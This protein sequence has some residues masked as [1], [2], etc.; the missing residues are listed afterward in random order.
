MATLFSVR[1]CLGSISMLAAFATISVAAQPPVTFRAGPD[2]KPVP[3]NA[4][5]DGSDAKPGTPPPGGKPGQKPGEEKKPGEDGK[6]DSPEPKVIRRGDKGEADPSELKATVGEDGRVAFQFR[7]QPWGELVQWLS[8]IT[9]QP[10]D[11]QE[12][13]GDRV[14]LASP[15]RYTVEETRDLFNRHLLSRGY[16]ILE[17]DGGLTIVKTAN[18]NPAMVPRV[19]VEELRELPPHTFVRTSLDVGWLSAEKLAQELTPMISSN[20]RLTALT[21]TNRIEAMDA[22]VNLSQINQ[23][24]IQERDSGSREALAPGI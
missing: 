3:V 6:N 22:A 13:P 24:L 19:A 8:D 10:L 5:P 18:I 12:L 9:E 7:N 21:T 23:L 14:N 2:G 16:T 20:G 15:G 4:K 1:A 17:L 11:W